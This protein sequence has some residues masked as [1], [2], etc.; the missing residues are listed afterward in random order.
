MTATG[1]DPSSATATRVRR[2]GVSASSHVAARRSAVRAREPG[3]GRSG[4]WRTRRNAASRGASGREATTRARS[5][6]SPSMRTTEGAGP[7]VSRTSCGN[8]AAPEPRSLRTARAAARRRRALAG[9]GSSASRRWLA[10]VS[11]R[12]SA[13]RSSTLPAARRRRAR[14][15][16]ARSRRR[17]T[18]SATRGERT[19]SANVSHATVSSHFETSVTP[20]RGKRA[21]SAPARA[22]SRSSASGP[23]AV[24]GHVVEDATERL[25]VVDPH[26]PPELRV[27]DRRESDALGRGARPGRE[28]LGRLAEEHLGAG[29]RRPL[30]PQ[31]RGAAREERRRQAEPRGV[32]REI[33]A[34]DDEVPSAFGPFEEG[35]GRETQRFGF[36]GR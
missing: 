8:G 16:A 20:G 2:V 4:A 9:S 33:A 21:R 36:L 10:S 32:G 13:V 15:G 19:D 35:I 23:S 30:G 27:E 25:A 6:I 31:P 26:V 22:R 5:P 14:S 29:V 28:A 17:E 7:R 1:P 24:A 34:D 18:P 11:R 3:T 12:A